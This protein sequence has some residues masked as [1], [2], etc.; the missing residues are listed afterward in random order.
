VRAGSDAA[1]AG[2]RAADRV[3][4]VNGAALRDAIDFQFHAADAELDL[5][6]ERDG[7]RSAL[8]IVRARGDL[9]V[10]LVPPKPGDIATCANKCVFC[11]IHQLPKGMR[12]SLYVKDDDYRLSFLHGNYIT[13]TDLDEA[14]FDRIV[15]QRLSPLYVSVHAT[16]PALRHRLLGQ[17][18]RSAEILPRLERLAKARI[19]VHAQIVLCPGLNDGPHLARTIGELA[20]LHPH[21]ATAAIVPVGLTR[22]RQRLPDLRV[23]TPDE[24]RAL[25]DTVTAWQE[26]SLP[27]L[28]SRFVFLADEIYLVADRPLPPARAYEGFPVI[29]DG[30]GLVRRFEDGWAR[31]LAHRR[32]RRVARDVTL[33]TGTMFGPR[34]ARLTAM[35]DDGA[36]A[37]VAVVPNDL[38][39][40]GIGVTGLL[41]GGDIQRHLAARGDLGEAVL[42]PSVTVRDGDGVFLDDVTPDDLARDL[43][44]AVKLVAPEPAALLDA[45]CR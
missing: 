25:V 9:G 32:A 45:L 4:T 7:A 14:A 3:L 34:L 27:R 2:L 6:I 39:G 38:F 41:T 22:H 21:V 28:G 10:E 40:H 33:V 43:G 12:R 36:R 20:P 30:I 1:A 5:E 8:T 18:R 29:E 24:A 15:E 31:S 23:L 13:L 11:F 26:D 42:I 16:D 35:L 37:R 19:R 17:P 44:V